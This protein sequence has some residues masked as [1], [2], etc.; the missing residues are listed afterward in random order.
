M[1]RST[2][3]GGTGGIV[4]KSTSDE[5]TF[6]GSKLCHKASP[7]DSDGAFRFSLR[8]ENLTLSRCKR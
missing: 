3:V 6:I 2:G 5:D 4:I 8:Y 1:T 7:P